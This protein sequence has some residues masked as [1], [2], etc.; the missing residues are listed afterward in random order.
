MTITRRILVAS[1]ILVAGCAKPGVP[2]TNLLPESLGVWRR[3]ALQEVS[4]PAD[5]DVIPRG[6]IRRVQK[7]R[8]EGAGNA[9]VTL[10]ELTSSA[11]A[12]D[13]VQRWRP[14]P[15]T[16]FFY[17]DEFF[18]VVKYQDAERKALN[19]LVRDLDKHLTPPK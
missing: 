19:A 11:A 17:R 10:Y 18:V 13:A 3:T 16:V 9:D 2:R 14:A 12:L 7:A 8:Y 5:T 15:D 6:S 1:A 4:N